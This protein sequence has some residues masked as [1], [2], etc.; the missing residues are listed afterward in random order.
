MPLMHLFKPK[1]QHPNPTVRRQAVASLS[2]GHEALTKVATEDQSPDVRI[3]ALSKIQDLNFLGSLL[4]QESDPS[5]R[6]YLARHLSELLAGLEQAAHSLDTRVE[7]LKQHPQETLLEYVALEGEEPELRH[8]AQGLVERQEVLGE[9]SV[10][11]PVIANRLAALERVTDPLVL[12]SV[13]R[14]TRKQD[15]QINRLSKAKLDAVRESE[16]RTATVRKESEKLCSR[17]EQMG[18]GGDWES[19]LAEFENLNQRWLSFSDA[20]DDGFRTRYA[21]AYEAFQ[22]ASANY[23]QAR[24]EQQREW[25]VGKEA[26]QRILTELENCLSELKGQERLSKDSES[27]LR[28]ALDN[29]QSSWKQVPELPVSQSSPL[30]TAYDQLSKD[31]RKRLDWHRR[32]RA[33]EGELNLLIDKAEKLLDGNRPVSEGQVKSLEKKWEAK[34]DKSVAENL[35][36][37]SERFGTLRS[38]LRERLIRQVDKRKKE[39]EQLPQRLEKL[40]KLLDDK[41]LKEAGPLHDRIQSSLDNLLAMDTPR[42]KLAP[43]V[44]RLHRIT[45]QVR[46]LQS[47]RTWGADEARERLCEEMEGL[48]GS[49]EPPTE[50][51]ARIRRLRSEWNRLRSDGGITGKTLRK[52][53]DAA[54]EKAYRP[55]EAHFKQQAELRQNNLHKRQGLLDKLHSYLEQVE[56]S[57]MDWKEAVKFHR[58]LSNDWR[59][60]GPVDR[61]ESKAIEAAYQE[62]M[63]VLQE[64]LELERERNLAQ[65]KTL[66]DKVRALMELE[67]INQAVDECK[68]LQGQWQTTVPGKRQ[69]ENELWREFREA[70]DAV[71][72]RRKEQ[73]QERQAEEQRHKARKQEICTDIER[74]SESTLDELPEAERRLRKLVDAW[75]E[76]GPVPKRDFTALEVRFEQAQQHFQDHAAALREAQERDQ[77]ELLRNKADVCRTLEQCLED[78]LSSPNLTEHEQRWSELPPLV[79]EALEKSMQQRFEQVCEALKSHAEDDGPRKRLLQALQENLEMRKELC[80]RMEIL[81]GVESP[82]ELQQAR[83]EFQANR[84]AEAMG[85][86]ENDPVGKLAELERSWYLTG[87]APASEEAV[88]QQRFAR[89]REATSR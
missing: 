33:T 89:A 63:G 15:K 24:E 16:E 30:D 65:R 42:E 75:K 28:M 79:E 60:A 57:H 54:A 29:W 18:Q 13:Y 62:A 80:L 74:L 86:G 7:F 61:R 67:E 51:A 52:R 41:V 55:C 40:E 47:W 69:L 12:E 34:Q 39:L 6:D 50:L 23:R 9:V 64:H 31:I 35:S 84:L 70:C 78:R 49:D 77:L 44:T 20:V 14:Q 43:F 8:V 2:A 38:Q 83:M 56:W 36:S 58:H 72:A 59:Q 17:L 32:L 25:A 46:E 68:Q 48:I 22:H 1:W 27:S 19:E 82:V 85:Q 10:K 81:S 66:I 88:L 71:F 5:V 37:Q 4:E 87:G 76:V 53:F 11:D 21:R 3:V 45:P 73:Q 26:R